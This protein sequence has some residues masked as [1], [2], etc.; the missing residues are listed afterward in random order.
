MSAL[1]KER[2]EPRLSTAEKLADLLELPVAALFPGVKPMPERR[3]AVARVD[4]RTL[5]RIREA[6]PADATELLEDVDH[7][8]TAA[9][10][11]TWSL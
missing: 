1:E 5:R 7:L 11:A 9:Q 3:A 6:L 2:T 8:I 10:E 4:V